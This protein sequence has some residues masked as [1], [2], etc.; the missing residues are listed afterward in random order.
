MVEIVLR[1]KRC[2]GQKVNEIVDPRKMNSVTTWLILFFSG[3]IGMSWLLLEKCQAPALSK[4]SSLLC[5]YSAPMF[6]LRDSG[7]NTSYQVKTEI[8]K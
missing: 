5:T 8:G 3:C 4:L 2:H 6:C 1:C 7:I